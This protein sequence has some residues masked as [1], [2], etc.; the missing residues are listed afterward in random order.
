M[1]TENITEAGQVAEDM[2]AD[3]PA[4]P[5]PADTAAD[6]EATEPA[7]A[8][9]PDAGAEEA[10][11]TPSPEPSAKSDSGSIV[12]EFR[13][14]ERINEE[15]SS[16]RSLFPDMKLSELPDEV[17][18]SISAGVPLDAACALHKLRREAAERL[19]SNVNESNKKLSS[20]AVRSSSVNY[21]TIEEIGAMSRGEVRK[22][23]GFIFKSLENQNKNRKE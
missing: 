10:S 7:A 12:D 13:R 9:A 11:V 14:L 15:Y 4:E 5:F 8:P 2:T 1:E 18:K 3:F 19:A 16:F 21:L 23:L 20:G 17:E 6:A 22:N